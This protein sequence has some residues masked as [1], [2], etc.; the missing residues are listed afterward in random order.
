ML[1]TEDKE[2]TKD[3]RFSLRKGVGM[4]LGVQVSPPDDKGV[5]HVEQARLGNG[6][7]LTQ[8]ELVGIG[9]TVYPK[10]CYIIR[11]HVYRFDLDTV[12]PD[13]IDAQM[14]EYGLKRKD[15]LR[16]LGI[17]PSSL[18]QI[19]S[20]VRG[21]TKSMKAMFFYYFNSYA[22]SRTLRSMG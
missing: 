1:E 21:K 12:T 10:K 20:G 6:V 9:R 17:D 19:M 7:I 15:L 22:L 5:V 18:S 4:Y 14:R 11:P 3:A 8:K 16:Q 2:L 13:W